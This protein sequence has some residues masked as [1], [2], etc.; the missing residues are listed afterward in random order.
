MNSEIDKEFCHVMLQTLQVALS[1]NKNLID[2]AHQQLKVLQVRQ[3]YIIFFSV[4]NCL[5]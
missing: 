4:I 5:Y 3:G 2:N 1:P